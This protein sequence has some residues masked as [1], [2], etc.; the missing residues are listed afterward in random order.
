VFLY[1]TESGLTKR[2][3]KFGKVARLKLKFLEK[4]F[5]E[6]FRGERKTAKSLQK[7]VARMWYHQEIGKVAWLEKSFFGK[8][9]F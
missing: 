3:G 1:A 2:L 9:F 6:K 4:Y 8:I 7:S 5:F